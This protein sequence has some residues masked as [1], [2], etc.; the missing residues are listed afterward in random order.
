MKPNKID[1]NNKTMDHGKS[2][3]DFL[4]EVDQQQSI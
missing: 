3:F 1:I 2:D 4:N